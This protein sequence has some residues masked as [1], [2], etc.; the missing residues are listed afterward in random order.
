MSMPKLSMLVRLVSMTR[1]SMSKVSIVES[2]SSKSVN[3][4]NI[5]AK[6]SMSMSGISVN[7]KKLFLC[8]C[9]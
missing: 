7:E 1:M 8:Q 5:N 4:N 6:V 2:V 3:A 9:G